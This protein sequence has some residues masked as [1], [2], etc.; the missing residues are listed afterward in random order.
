MN[1][2]DRSEEAQRVDQSYHMLLSSSS[3]TALGSK[4]P[5][6]RSTTNKLPLCSSLRKKERWPRRGA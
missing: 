1:G 4:V 2:A 5:R 3:R 6:P